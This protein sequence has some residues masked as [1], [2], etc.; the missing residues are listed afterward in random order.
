MTFSITTRDPDTSMFGIAVATSAIAGA[1][2][3]P[4]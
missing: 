3:A 1:T 2:A 4:E